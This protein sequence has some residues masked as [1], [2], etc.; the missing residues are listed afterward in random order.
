[1]AQPIELLEQVRASDWIKRTGRITRFVGLTVEANGPDA[2]VGE[3]CEIYSKAHASGT[4]AEVV[5]FSDGK[6]QLMPFEDLH[7]IEIGS[8]ITATGRFADVVVGEHLFGRVIDGFG[9]PLPPEPGR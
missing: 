2:R 1:M 3:L 6:V 5:G 7:G 4:L 8:E 9:A